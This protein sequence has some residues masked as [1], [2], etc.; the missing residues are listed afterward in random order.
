MLLLSPRLFV[1]DNICRAFKNFLPL[2]IPPFNSKVT[3]PPPLLICFLAMAYCGCVSRNGY[4]TVLICGC[5]C[6]DTAS[7]NALSACLSIRTYKVS[8]LFV[9][10]HALKGLMDGPVLR[11]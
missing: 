8:K 10:T 9:S 2:S 6:N 3:I 7:F 1:M 11:M 4:F 5:D